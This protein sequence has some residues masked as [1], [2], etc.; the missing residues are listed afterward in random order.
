MKKKICIYSACDRFNYG[1]LLF[2]I[3]LTK[4]EE[5]IKYFK[6]I[7]G[8]NNHTIE[9]LTKTPFCVVQNIQKRREGYNPERKHESI[10]VGDSFAYGE[11]VKDEDTLAYLLNLRFDGINFR[12]FANPFQDIDDI[13]NQLIGISNNSNNNKNIIYFYN[14]NDALLSDELRLQQKFIIDFQNIRFKNIYKN[15]PEAITSL[16]SRSKIINL[17]GKTIIL[18]I[19]SKHTIDY[20]LDMYFDSS[21]EKEFNQTIK[22]MVSA[23]NILKSKNISFQ[24]II[25]PLF[26]KNLLGKYPFIRI[27]NHLL[28][29][30]KENNISCI[31][32]YPVFG[33]YYS[34]KKFIVHPLDYHPNGL[35][36]KLVVDY[37]VE[38]E[39]FVN[40][41][42][43]DK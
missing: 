35:A 5:Y 29:I 2:P 34:L 6:K 25:Y 32:L 43:I 41:L 27:H 12:N 9:G 13:Y 19:E 8:F 21:N 10:I 31:D 4:S 7:F 16:L 1:D 36:N 42:K 37:L 22:Q 15:Y 24:V 39:E 40:E 26:Y 17:I 30:C 33:K 14:L 23:N 20:Y 18:Q 38:N 28:D 11:G 3:V